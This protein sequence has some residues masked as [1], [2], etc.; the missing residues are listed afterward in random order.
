MNIPFYIPQNHLKGNEI[1]ISNFSDNMLAMLICITTF[2]I[3]YLFSLHVKIVK[4]LKRKYRNWFRVQ[5]C[6]LSH[7]K[8]IHLK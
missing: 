5:N 8:D 1:V 4:L 2:I 6:P 3:E 7:S